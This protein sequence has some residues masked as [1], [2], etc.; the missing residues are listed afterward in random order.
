MYNCK[1]IDL[2]VKVRKLAKKKD[3][4]FIFLQ[5]WQWM[6]NI[7]KVR[8]SGVYNDMCIVF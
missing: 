2:H 7:H 8:K 1:N 3:I 5:Q 6:M 4:Y